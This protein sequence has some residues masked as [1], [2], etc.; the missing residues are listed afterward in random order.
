MNTNKCQN[1]NA[2]TGC[3]HSRNHQNAIAIQWD[4]QRSA[5]DSVWLDCFILV[6]SV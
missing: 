2:T 6:S 3:R 1:E 5:T 4:L